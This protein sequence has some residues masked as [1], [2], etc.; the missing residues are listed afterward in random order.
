M[1]DKIAS[2]MNESF[3]S[4][5]MDSGLVQAWL[6]DQDTRGVTSFEE[7]IVMEDLLDIYLN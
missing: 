3:G 4:S 7:T 1:Y 6:Q 5:D 2:I